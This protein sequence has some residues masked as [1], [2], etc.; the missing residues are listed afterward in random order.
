[1]DHSGEEEEDDLSNSYHSSD[2]REEDNLSSSSHGSDA[3]TGSEDCSGQEDCD[4][5]PSN[6]EM[7]RS[8]AS[9]AAY[10]P[11]VYH[12]VSRWNFRDGFFRV[13]VARVPLILLDSIAAVLQRR[14][15][16]NTPDSMCG[17]LPRAWMIALAQKFPDTPL[18]KIR[19]ANPTLLPRWLLKSFPDYKVWIYSCIPVMYCNPSLLP[20]WLPK[21]FVD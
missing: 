15:G 8:H 19:L 14:P 17:S 10:A 13:C 4:N 18:S 1:M 20:A 11:Q 16:Q 21:C 2:D 6:A 12:A 9:E 5:W 3:G 7:E